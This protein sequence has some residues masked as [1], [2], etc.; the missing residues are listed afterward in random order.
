MCIEVILLD[1]VMALLGVVEG[2]GTWQS[3]SAV[4]RR[5]SMYGVEKPTRK[6]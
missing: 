5:L 4:E 3:S 1:W 6:Q 2:S